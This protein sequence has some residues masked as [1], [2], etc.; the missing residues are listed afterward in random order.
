MSRKKRTKKE[1]LPRINLRQGMDFR[2][3]GGKWDRGTLLWSF[4]A[5]PGRG[6][7]YQREGD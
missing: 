3:E 4:G 2:E 6:D 7:D 5:G 1:N